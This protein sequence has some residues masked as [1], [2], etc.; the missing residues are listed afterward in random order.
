MTDW[1]PKV[2]L[3]FGLMR[4]PKKDNV[5]VKEE[6][7]RLVD[8][9]LEKG[10]TYFD[11]AYVYEGS[12][13]AF[14]L[15]VSERH[16]RSEY[17]VANKLP[18]WLLSDTVSNQDLFQES[19]RRCGV[20]YFDF[21]LLHAI[22]REKIKTY[23]SRGCFEF[24]QQ[25]KKEGKI[26]HFGFSFH[27]T[28]DVLKDILDRH[29]DVDFVQLQVNY[30]DWNDAE[31]QSKEN[32]E[33]CRRR[34]IPVIIMEPVKGGTLSK[35]DDKVRSILEKAC[36]EKTPSQVA[37]RFCASLN[38]VPVILSG[39]NTLDQVKENIQAVSGTL[40]RPEINAVAEAT[41]AL[42][43]TP[44]VGCTACRYCCAGC[45]KKIE[46]PEIFK[47]LNQAIKGDVAGAREKYRDLIESG[48]SAPAGACIRCG[49]CERHCPQ[50]LKI[51]SLLQQASALFDK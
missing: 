7:C 1:T 29:P 38:N 16:A 2:R 22:D 14:R 35:P 25:L 6:T 48:R 21:Y 23:E 20:D 42:R 37:I 15:C 40:T 46:I 19:L 50:H 51:I 30:L 43:Q 18:G 47:C 39:M 45:P 5:I 44:D 27:D 34:R 28:A 4:L 49:Q 33:V 41:L 8:S 32:Y 13:E 31:V 36:P 3:G 9:F 11:T 24:C 17:T 10:G 12:E 26:K